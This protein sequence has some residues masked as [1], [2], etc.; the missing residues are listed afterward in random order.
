M[1]ITD[2]PDDSANVR[3]TLG[4]AQDRALRPGCLRH[5][6]PDGTVTIVWPGDMLYSTITFLAQEYWRNGEWRRII[7]DDDHE[8]R[9]GDAA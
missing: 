6:G 1:K 5:T 4:T 8:G 3:P 2:D 9:G 7:E